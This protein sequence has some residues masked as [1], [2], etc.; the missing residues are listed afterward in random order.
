MECTTL[1]F[2]VLELPRVL[3]DFLDMVDGSF[4]GDRNYGPPPFQCA[5]AKGGEEESV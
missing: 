5:G 4:W 1:S 2:F 3:R